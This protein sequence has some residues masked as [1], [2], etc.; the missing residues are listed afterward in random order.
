MS[1]TSLWAILIIAGDPLCQRNGVSWWDTLCAVI[2]GVR[3]LPSAEKSQELSKNSISAA[4]RPL[5]G[6]STASDRA[7]GPSAPWPNFAV[8]W[9]QYKVHP[10]FILHYCFY[11]GVQ[12][13]APRRVSFPLPSS[14]QVCGP[15][16]PHSTNGFAYHQ[17]VVERKMLK[18]RLDGHGHNDDN[19]TWRTI[20]L[21][22]FS[23][24]SCDRS[25]PGLCPYDSEQW[26]FFSMLLCHLLGAEH[27]SIVDC[28]WVP[29]GG[30]HS[31]KP[32][33]G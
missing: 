7:G 5:F 16:F 6:S 4:P 1:L 9:G 3:Y 32:F 27:L 30:Q 22:F 15:C 13:K 28:Q 29:E 24:H 11:L 12:P 25:Y 26:Y 31:V 14:C 2:F 21:P 8:N 33:H 10:F 19:C 17:G 18:G 23:Q 20:H